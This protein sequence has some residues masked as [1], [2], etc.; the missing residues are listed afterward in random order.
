MTTTSQN[1]QHW[2]IQQDD[3]KIL[4][5]Y[6]DKKDATANSINNEV[7]QELE[8]IIENANGA[9]GLIIASK[10]KSGFIAGADLLYLS[11][12][13][14]IPAMVDFIREGQRVLDKLANM[15][16]P[17]VALIDGFCLGGGL[18]LSLACRYRIVEDGE[19]T[20]LGLPEVLLGIHPGWGGTVRLPRVIRIQSALDMMMSGRTISG[21]AAA[22]IGLADIAVP[23]RDLVMAATDYIKRKPAVHKISKFDSILNASWI[24]PIID[25][26][27]RRQLRGKVNPEHYPAPYVVLDNWEQHGLEPIPQAL[28]HEALSIQRLLEHPTAKNLLRVFLLRDELKSAAKQTETII[29]HVHV[30]GAGTM[31]GDIAAWCALRG[32]EVTL[33]DREAKFI[34]PAIKRAAALFAKKHKKP[35]EARMTMDRLMVDVEGHGIARADIIIEAVFEDLK[36]KQDLFKSIEQQAKPTAILATNTSSFPLDEISQFMQQ[37]DRLVGIHFFN[38]VAQMQLVEVVR[39]PK[40][41]ATIYQ[42]AKG[43]V[44][45][46]DK[47]P[48]GVISTP[49]FLVNRALLPYLM[50][51]LTM[52][53]EGVPLAV[54]DAAA[55]NFGM[56][57]G[58]IELSDTVGLDVCLLVA[59]HLNA[60]YPMNIPEKLRQL[61]AEK[62]LGRKTGSGFYTYVKGK[63]VKHEVNVAKGSEDLADRLILRML[64][65]LAACMREGVVDSTDLADAGMIFGTGFA[66]FLGGPFNYAKTQGIAIIEQ[67]LRTLQARYG[68]RFAPDAGWNAL[69]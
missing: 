13:D 8:S 5:A 46:L 47:L 2:Q 39:G 54:I 12:L 19:K 63:P 64:N 27:A 10:K 21:K 57:M 32:F 33:Q 44:K 31:G 66:P 42:Q 36:I 37:P 62:K 30:I 41:N 26:M 34:A 15:T 60:Y 25:R 35:I 3:Q 56:P 43:F 6:F 38:P 40:T 9:S 52:V 14:N 22:K 7:L 58:P 29:K 20:K 24:R 48:L 17:T 65:E 16:I 51:S 11:S 61:V 28:E 68:D 69:K 59:E 55:T 50:E 23:R 67:K 49:G 4:W 45:S 18:E 1:Y 53:S